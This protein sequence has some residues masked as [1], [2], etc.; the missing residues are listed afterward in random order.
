MEIA[1]YGIVEAYC[2]VLRCLS[3]YK[4]CWRLIQMSWLSVLQP[5]VLHCYCVDFLKT[6]SRLLQK[7]FH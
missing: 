2:C 6:V 7:C 5:S 1:I 3:V 4:R